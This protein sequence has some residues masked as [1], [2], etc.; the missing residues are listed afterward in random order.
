MSRVYITTPL[1]YVNAAPHIGHAYST[2]AADCLARYHRLRGDEVYFLTGTDEHGQKIAQAAREQGMEPK[3]FVDQVVGTFQEL[4]RLLGIGYDDFIRTT[5]SRHVKTVQAILERLH[6]EGKLHRFGYSSWYCTP[7]ETFWTVGD[8]KDAGL[9]DAA[10]QKGSCP[11]CKRPVAMMEEDTFNLKLEE[12]RLWLR[13]Y[14]QEHP[15]FIRPEV[16]RNEVLSL[17]ERPLPEYLCITRDRNRVSWGIGVPFSQQHVVY[18]WFDAL[19]NY[20]SAV[21][22]ER[23]DE[24][25]RRW[26]PATIHMIGKDILRHHAIYWPIMLH[27]LGFSDDQMPRQIFAHGWWLV[28]QSKMSKSV[29]NVVNPVELVGRY[30]ADA[31]RYFLLREAPFGSDGS[32]SEDALVLRINSDLAN[33]LGNLLQR[34]LHIVEQSFGG[35]LPPLAAGG[36]MPPAFAQRTAEITASVQALPQRLAEAMERRAFDAALDAIWEPVRSGNRLLDECKPWALVKSGEQQN[37]GAVLASV[38][39]TLRAVV[40]ALSPWM[41]TTTQEMWRRLGD[42]SPFSSVT[43]SDLQMFDLLKANQAPLLATGMRI[44]RGAPLFPRIA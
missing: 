19:I 17:L 1:Y 7:C 22:Y 26:W 21:E 41:P 43:L 42:P 20:I 23:D 13:R 40:I 27:A 5:E 3:A 35:V 37:A 10:S 39:L 11:S 15:T 14:V 8:L 9:W 24:Q 38:A 25:F 31:L 28:G 18:V 2:V 12:S 16:R 44:E 30:G 34:S 32:F 33:D 4:W 6:R 36:T 29:G